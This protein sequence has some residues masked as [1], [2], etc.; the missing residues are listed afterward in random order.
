MGAPSAATSSAAAG[1]PDTRTP[2]VGRAAVSGGGRPS[3]AGSTSVRGPGQKRDARRRAAAGTT[4]ATVDAMSRSF[5]N[6]RIG[7]PSSLP[8][9]RTSR[10]TA[11]SERASAPMPYTVSVGNTTRPPARRTFAA[12]SI[13]ELREEL[14]LEPQVLALDALRQLGLVTLEPLANGAALERQYLRRQ[15][16]R[17]LRAGTP[18]RDR[19]DGDARRHLDGGEQRIQPEE[20]GR[21]HRHR[22]HG[23]RRVRRD[24]AAEMRCPARPDDDH[25]DPAPPCG[26]RV[27]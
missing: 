25:A 2:I 7:F 1:C 26:G 15:D 4:A 9:T 8:R 5:T 17:V 27:A 10:S 3:R 18:D 20:R 6:T 11:V 19:R 12:A 23:K 16:G 21:R 13:C 22:D 24:D 14:P